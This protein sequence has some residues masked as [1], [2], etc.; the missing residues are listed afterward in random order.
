MSD[1]EMTNDPRELIDRSPMSKWQVT[2]ITLCIILISLDGF[3]VLSISFAAPGIAQEWGVDRAALGIVLSMEL[4]GMGLGAFILG[5]LADRFG[6]RPTILLSLAMMS[7]GMYLASVANSVTELS[8]VRLFTGIG[9][10]GILAS[11]SAMAAEF[12]NQRNRNLSVSLMAAGY[13]M[14]VIVGGSIASLLLASFDWRSVFIFGAVFTL[15][16][17]PL[18]WLLMPESISY[19]A[20]KRPAN[21]LQRINRALKRMG[22]ATIEVLPTPA[23]QARSSITRLFRPDL[24]R[25]TLL[26][27]LAY[28]THITTFYYLIKWIPKLVADMG[29]SPALSGSV[30]VWANVGG[31]C[32]AVLLGLLARRYSVS[33]LVIGSLLAAAA[34]VVVFGSGQS[35]LTQLSLVAGIAGFFI[36]AAIVGMY[37][38]FAQ[39]YP[40]EVRAGGTGFVIGAGRGGAV[41]GPVLAGFLLQSGQGGLLM[42]SMIMGTGSLIAAV[43]L[44]L[45]PRRAPVFS[46][47]STVGQL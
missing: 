30:L 29:Y 33:S 8:V 25:S 21:A 20:H 46:T 5:H 43:A 40:T 37:A 13:P 12:S 36:N 3:D 18:A 31:V 1:D 32:G 22:H 10:G 14:G 4:I 9:I 39:I 19:L 6:R 38:L 27:T 28:F 7:L 42:V 34:M 35:S 11:V 26:L 24:I 17:L 47:A 44:F 15:A 16:F 23:E 41:L 45:L 2:I